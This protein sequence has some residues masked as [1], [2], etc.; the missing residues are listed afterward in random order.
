METIMFVLHWANNNGLLLP[1]L[2]AVG[3]AVLRGG[4]ALLRARLQ[5]NYP[6]LAERGDVWVERL[7][8]LL[9]DLLRAV[10][11]PQRSAQ[12]M[13]SPYRTPHPPAEE[14]KPGTETSKEPASA[15]GAGIA[16]MVAAALAGAV[17]LAACPRLPEQSDC[18]PG[19]QRCAGDQPQVCSGSSRWTPV[20]DISCH[21]VGA[22]CVHGITAH[23]RRADAGVQ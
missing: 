6:G 23:C 1:V 10:F 20:G 15:G 11:P 4:W 8:A 18:T 13:L 17:G 5:K 9:P 3:L 7:A 21:E 19:A 16:L 14:V 12:Q 2:L 22:V